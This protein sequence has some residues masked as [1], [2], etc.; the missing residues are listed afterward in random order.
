M[1][2]LESSDRLILNS[3][4]RFLVGELDNDGAADGTGRLGL[5][6]RAPIGGAAPD[7][8]SCPI[9]EL[10]TPVPEFDA[11]VT[12]T[13]VVVR[14]SARGAVRLTVRDADAADPDGTA[15]LADRA[16]ADAGETAVPLDA[17]PAGRTVYR[18]AASL[19]NSRGSALSRL[20]AA[21]APAE[22]VRFRT[23]KDPLPLKFFAP[24]DRPS[25]AARLIA[26]PGGRILRR[27]EIASCRCT[28]YRLIKNSRGIGRAPCGTPFGSGVELPLSTVSDAASASPP[29]R[30][31]AI[32][33]NFRWTPDA[34]L[35]DICGGPGFYD[36]VFT[37]KV[38]CGGSIRFT[39]SIPLRP[40]VRSRTGDICPRLA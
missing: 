13:A 28:V 34:P 26:Y 19:A 3:G 14:G 27:D 22:R 31:D 5:F 21:A 24:D 18:L 30:R 10:E 8:V 38:Q 35:G 33:G 9:E 17:F 6:W 11:V 4:D 2:L 25:F 23:V 16:I 15:P 12:T 36:V 32:G 29:W 37:V 1:L 40:R 39:F 20:I 7:R